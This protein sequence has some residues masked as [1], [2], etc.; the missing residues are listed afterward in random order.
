MPV[1]QIAEKEVPRI[2]AGSALSPVDAIFRALVS[3]I[4][5]EATTLDARSW[6]ELESLVD[7]ALRDRSAELHRQLRLLLRVIEWF[8]V[9]RYGR[10]FTALNASHRARVLCYL[11]DHWI[12]QSSACA[13]TSEMSAPALWKNMGFGPKV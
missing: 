2:G 6:A 4:V 12:E 5:P 11:Q 9:L 8:P 7:E 13:C 3:T 1:R 10:P